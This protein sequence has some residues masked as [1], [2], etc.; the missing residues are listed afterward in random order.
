MTPTI[1]P[2]CGGH[3]DRCECADLR[4]QAFA[5]AAAWCNARAERHAEFAHLNPDD[6]ERMAAYDIAAEH[7]EALARKPE[8]L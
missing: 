7:F 3:V 6:D 2:R 1:C 4:R 5:E 8:P